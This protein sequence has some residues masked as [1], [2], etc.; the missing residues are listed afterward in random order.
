MLEACPLQG[1]VGLPEIRYA[2]LSNLC[3][4]MTKS[5]NDHN[6][7]CT[8]IHLHSLVQSFINGLA[9]FLEKR[10]ETTD[11]I[12]PGSS[13]QTPLAQRVRV[14]LSFLLRLYHQLNAIG[15]L[16][17][18]GMAAQA[19]LQLRSL[20]EMAID[21]RYIATNPD[22]LAKLY[23]LHECTTRY[24]DGKE[25]QNDGIEL[26]PDA[27]K[28]L[29]ALEPK[30][31]DYLALLAKVEGKTFD[32]PPSASWTVRKIGDRANQAYRHFH[33]NE[34]IYLL[35]KWLCISMHGEARSQRDFVRKIN[36]SIALRLGP[37]W[38]L[39][40][41]ILY[42]SLISAGLMITAAKSMGAP[43]ELRQFDFDL[44]L[45][46]KGVDE[47]LESEGLIESIFTD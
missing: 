3:K 26:H 44:G 30:V 31:Q 21:L 11:W 1:L 6:R 16:T 47:I 35:Y 45:D 32:K 8:A 28:N 43:I 25:L 19:K 46:Q 37:S 10:E 17:L 22:D 7:S 14:V 39:E 2:C 4:A 33:D 12:L 23:L 24:R 38:H 18:N 15:L 29:A 40:A 41:Y 20:V 36:G 5:D 9:S 27:L 34:K 13:D 42:L